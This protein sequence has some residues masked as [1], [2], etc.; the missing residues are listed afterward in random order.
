MGRAKQ[1]ASAGILS[2]CSPEEVSGGNLS[3]EEPAGV[4]APRVDVTMAGVWQTTRGDNQ[5]RV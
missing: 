4:A 1:L 5:F 3:E 2:L